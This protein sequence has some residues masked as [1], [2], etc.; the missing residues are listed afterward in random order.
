MT[1]VETRTPTGLGRTEVRRQEFA[2][3]SDACAFAKKQRSRGLKY[4]VVRGPDRLSNDDFACLEGLG[5]V[6]L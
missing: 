5:V 2:T 3:V 6:R 4:I 1:A